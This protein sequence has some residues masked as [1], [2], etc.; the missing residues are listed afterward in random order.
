MAFWDEHDAG[1]GGGGYVTP[2]EKK[3]LV[4]SEQP[5]DVVAVRF[6]EDGK[7]GPRYVVTLILPDPATGE[8]ETRFWG[9]QKGTGADGRDRLLAAMIDDHFGAGETTPIACIAA[10][11]GRA[12][13]LLPAPGEKEEAKP[14]AKAKTSAKA[15]A[16]A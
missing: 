12:F 5:F 14:A 8:D 1:G 11:G 2:D 15:K 3:E 9:F 6:E 7:F 16:K 10:M 13:V 4:D